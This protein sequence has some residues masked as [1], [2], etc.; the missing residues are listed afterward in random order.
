[1]KAEYKRDLQNNYLI[2][3][4]N[5]EKEQDGYCL[6]MAEQ[7]EIQGLLEF[8][9]F[10]RDGKQYL[11]YEITSRQTLEGLYERKQMGYQ[12]ILNVLT[13]IRDTMET[14]QRYLLEPAHLI[15][16]PEY[17]FVGTDRRAAFCYFPES[18]QEKGILA[19][20]E[21]ILRKLDHEDAQAVN[22]GYRFYQSVCEENFSL[23]RVWKELIA[24][25]D[26]ER[27][28]RTK[29]RKEWLDADLSS[30]PGTGTESDY[31]GYEHE[32]ESQE[33]EVIH[34][35]RRKKKVQKRLDYLLARV[36]PLVILSGLFLFAVIEI[37]FYFRFID[38]TEAGGMFFLMLSAEL[39]INRFWKRRKEKR[40]TYAIYEEQESESRIYEE[41]QE[42]M[43][44]RE[45]EEE[46]G[47]TCC[48]TSGLNQ[49]G[50]RLIHIAGETGEEVYPDICLS[51]EVLY[52]GKRKGESHVLLNSPTVSRMHARLEGR[53]SRYFVKDLNS[54]N[55]T[56]CN[57]QRLSPQEERE[58]TVGDRVTF[59]QIAYRV[60]RL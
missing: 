47:E 32:F 7:N 24:A 11:H 3:E 29:V 60:V 12:E 16:A 34:K 57:E 45:E 21:F 10:K 46:I 31:A 13:D 28:Q 33:F 30:E 36:H 52:V 23:G 19:L 49:T 1:M 41:L 26:E 58:I 38:L 20:A 27:E 55:G 53:D 8:H 17:I 54:R 51:N 22:L 44:Q 56:F 9:S 6:R 18:R 39:L 2:L 37:L 48:L 14:M 35:E 43:Y 4:L 5:Q 25:A 59:A 15:F 42:E 50:I 40:K